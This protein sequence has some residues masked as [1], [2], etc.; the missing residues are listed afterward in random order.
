MI[1]M[2]RP[3]LSFLIAIALIIVM[4]SLASAQTRSLQSSDFYKLRSVGEVQFSPDGTR[5]AYTVI[6]NDG[7][8]R[9]YAQLWIMSLADGKSIRIGGEKESSSGPEWSPDGQWLAYH[10]RLGD[11][12][13][14]IVARP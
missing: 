12:S 5:L 3:R 7:P 6:N 10:G 1:D 9:P 2:R 11:K 13:G 8:R 4:I 14:L